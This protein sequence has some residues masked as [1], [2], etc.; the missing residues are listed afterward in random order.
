MR[1]IILIAGVFACAPLPPAPPPPATTT[2]HAP[3]A[4]LAVADE[5]MEFAI[6]WR[7]VTVGHVQVAVGEPGYVH[8]HHAII[9]RSR[10]TTDGL[11]ALLGDLTWELTTTVDL[12]SGFPIESLE[13]SSARL[14]NGKTEHEERHHHQDPGDRR[15]D[16][17][18]LAGVLRGSAPE[19]GQRL[20]LEV[21][22]GG[23]LIPIV[24]W[25]DG[26]EFLPGMKAPSVRYAGTAFRRPF[27]LWLSDDAQRVPQRLHAASRWGSIDVS[28]IDYR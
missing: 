19:V 24:I 18:S 13:V 22:I 6:A 5:L 21:D 9:V 7:G 12:D 2:A 3:R 1:G 16:V 8:E 15:H 14:L 26:R 20:E 23:A 17:H 10:G 4:T 25:L 27:T 28:L 11:L